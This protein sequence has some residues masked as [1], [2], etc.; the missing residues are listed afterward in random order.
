MQERMKSCANPYPERDKPVSMAIESLSRSIAIQARRL[1]K[2]KERGKNCWELPCTSSSLRA[3]PNFAAGDT[4]TYRL[5]NELDQTERQVVIRIKELRG[6][7][8]IYSNGSVG[9]LF[10]NNSRAV[11]SDARTDDFK[12]SNHN[13][14]FP[15]KAGDSWKFKA[16]QTSGERVMDLDIS[17]KVGDEEEVDTPAGKMR[18]VRIDREVRWKQSK[19]ENGG[20]NLRTYWYSSAVKRFESRDHATLARFR[21]SFALTASSSVSPKPPEPQE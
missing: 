2:W 3:P 21:R 15:L 6:D 4:W 7:E 14:V 18:G 12:P 11:V 8:V 20:I 9:D 16:L 5:V 10:G 17:I 13:Y 1:P 19:S